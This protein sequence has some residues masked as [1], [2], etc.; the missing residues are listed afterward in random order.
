V[1]VQDSC[2]YVELAV[3]G[4]PAIKIKFV[5]KCQKEPW[6]WTDAFY[7][8]PKLRKMDVRIGTWNARSL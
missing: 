1:Y 7:K 4:A 3:T 2:E 8:L 5:M 6:N